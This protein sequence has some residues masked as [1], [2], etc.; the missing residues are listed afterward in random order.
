VGT[1][2]VQLDPGGEVLA[3]SV[4][5][6]RD[7]PAL[8]RAQA[9]AAD[10]SAGIEI[11][12][13]LLNLK[14]EGQRDAVAQMPGADDAGAQLDDWVRRCDGARSIDELLEIERGAAADYWEA[15]LICR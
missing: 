10:G 13:H 9:L 7:L 6:G 11:T 1:A 4:T 8:R 3:T 14:V 12:K 15:W 5:N 2:Y